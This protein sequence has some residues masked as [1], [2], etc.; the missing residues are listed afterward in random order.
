[1][2]G[3]LQDFQHKLN[4]LDFPKGEAKI[5][6]ALSGGLDSVVLLD[7]LSKSGFSGFIAHVNYGLRHDDSDKDEAL[8]RQLAIL[9]SWEIEVLD[10][11]NSMLHHLNE[12]L[13]MAARRIRYD[14][15]SELEKKHHLKAI[16][17]AHHAD[18][19]I[20]TFF[21]KLLRGS[22]S[23]AM[24]GMSEQN[25]VYF[26]PLLDFTKE[27]LLEYAQ[28]NKLTWREDLSNQSVKYLRNA[29]RLNLLPELKNVQANYLQ[30]V[31]ESVGRLKSEQ[32]QLSSFTN[33]W[34]ELHVN[35]TE[36][37]FTVLK[38]DLMN[39]ANPQ[40]LIH[41]L[42]KKYGFSWRL[43]GCIAQ[44]LTNTHIQHFKTGGYS[45]QLNR[46]Y[47]AVNK[48]VTKVST[49]GN[50]HLPEVILNYFDEM[51]VDIGFAT[52]NEAWVLVDNIQGELCLRKWQK[53]DFFWPSGM[54]GR[55]LLS[56]Y[57]T[58]IKLLPQ[59]R[60]EQWILTCN[61]EVVWIVNRR[62]DRRFAAS[63]TSKNIVRLTIA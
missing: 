8:A 13:Q 51:P 21:I 28:E 48:V 44:N 35:Q 16:F 9:Y 60:E 1:M 40:F 43:C 42:L 57:F 25:G 45:V 17:L 22:G 23:E 49:E 38:S 62:I 3:L 14:W 15:F 20:E 2:S 47:L 33:A 36:H 50:V 46:V 55:K 39:E 24:S 63:Q 29:I 37:G 11:K 41:E 5:L 58:D 32:S 30:M 61:N 54:N 19:Q 18:D 12:S 4:T 52:K 6:L 31:L 34:I 27:T 56:D 10:A 26:R 53:G 59:E 7:L